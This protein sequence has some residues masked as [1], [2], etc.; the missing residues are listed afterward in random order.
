MRSQLKLWKKQE[1][2]IVKLLY[3]KGFLNCFN[4]NEFY[5]ES[6]KSLGRRYRSKKGY[7]NLQY[8]PEV[9]YSTKDYWGETDENS[10]VDIIK[11][12]FYYDGELPIIKTRQGFINYLT[13]LPTT[14]NDSKI[15]KILKT[16]YLDY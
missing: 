5:W 14:V 9:H 16:N 1:K 13:S 11:S 10:I 8:L 4:I 6:Y 2:R 7:L 3:K 12:F 15:N